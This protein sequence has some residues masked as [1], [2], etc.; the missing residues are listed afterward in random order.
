VL[1]NNALRALLLPRKWQPK[2]G[3]K[4][5]FT[6]AN[7]R[8]A[9]LI[10][11]VSLAFACLVP[12]ALITIIH[13]GI[14]DK[15]IG[16]ERLLRAERVASNARRTVGNFLLER[17]DALRYVVNEL[18]FI[19][20][21][22]NEQLE[23]VLKNLKVG[24][25]G[26]SDLGVIR[27]DGTQVAYVGTFD[28]KGK[29][30]KNEQWFQGCMENGQYISDVFS[31][32]RGEPHIILCVK[33][34]SVSGE[35]FILRTTVDTAKLIEIVRSHQ[36]SDYADIFLINHQGI[37]QTPSIKY[38]PGDGK[39]KV[40]FDLPAYSSRTQAVEIKDFDDDR[41][42]LGYAQVLAGRAKTPFILINIKQETP[43][44]LTEVKQKNSLDTIWSESKIQVQR[45]FYTSIFLIVLIIYLVATFMI[46]RLYM[47][48][49]IKAN[50]LKAAERKSQLASV[51]QLAA[52]VAHEI[53]NPL[54]VINEEAGYLMDVIAT[55]ETLPG[56]SELSEH[57]QSILDSVD[58]CGSITRQLLA[59]SRQFDLKIMKF[60]PA[61]IVADI[62]KF[63]VK[64]AFYRNITLQVKTAPET[65][66]IV[67][68]KGKFQQILVNLVK[69]AFQ[70]LDDGGVLSVDIEPFSKDDISIIVKDNGCG[71][72][73][74]NLSRIFDPFFTTKGESEGTGL[75]LS[76]TYGLVQQLQGKINVNS[77]A[78]KGTTFKM[79]FPV[80][81]QGESES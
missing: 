51:G 54:A 45:I 53:N 20:L 11:I 36:T 12:L 47:S 24:F 66:S 77:T 50:T 3:M 67:S 39:H 4:S 38:G 8:R 59:F 79:I 69:N 2:P 5:F 26:I 10:L 19:E 80:T 55:E 73:K 13:Q 81:M 48:D 1:K 31:G 18:D 30:Y 60:H 75:G 16:H 62:L 15:A 37:L 28:L 46:N 65:P 25:G 40:Q 52:G 7:Y 23:I 35:S 57:L 49:S 58:R 68:D 33:S 61:D 72:S 41:L 17:M 32:F 56:R 43:F 64:E 21:S 76:I 63:Y 27:S 74:E 34:L 9:W 29:D 71:I 42:V 22:Q 14:V 44:H 70:A 78:G 6:F